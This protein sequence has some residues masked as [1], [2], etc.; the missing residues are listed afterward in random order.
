MFNY[1]TKIKA[2]SI[3]VLVVL[4]ILISVA[5]GFYNSRAN[6]IVV[7][8]QAK[9]LANGLE[10]HYDKFNI[11]PVNEKVKADF[12]TTVS[13]NGFNQAGAIIYWQNHDKWA[14]EASYT[15]D[16]NNYIIRFVVNNKWPMWGIDTHKG[17]ICTM[18]TNMNINCVPN[19]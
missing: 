7:F 3:A 13:D 15:S 14:R 19:L 5:I 10:K 4:I 12:L 17:G 6:D 18:A 11:Y 2:I 1:S 8:N 16:G 9:S